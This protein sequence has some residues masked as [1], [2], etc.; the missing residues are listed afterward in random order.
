MFM[1][2]K[3]LQPRSILPKQLL[4]PSPSPLNFLNFSR[5]KE[6][7]VDRNM[8]RGWAV[9]TLPESMS[10]VYSVQSPSS[11]FPGSTLPVLPTATL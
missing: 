4:Y 11:S 6:E 7:T 9:W 3:H 10:S 8:V 1:G 5:W 2:G